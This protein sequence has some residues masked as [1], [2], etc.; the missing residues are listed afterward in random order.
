MKP[1]KIIRVLNTNAV[2]S[3]DQQDREIIITG[4]GIGFKKKKGE[5]LDKSLVEKIYFL[6]NEEDNHRLQEVVKEIS[7]KYLEIAGKVVTCAREQN[8]KIKDT[9]YVTLTDHINSAVER[10]Q[11]G[12]SLKNMMRHEIKKF[13]PQEYALGQKAIGWIEK[14]TGINLGDDEAAF[15]AMHIVSSEFETSEVSDVQKITEL[16]NAIVKIV[17]MHFKIDFHE[18][19]VSYQRFLTHL[20]FF[21]ARVMD[22]E[23]YQDSM[24]EI[25]RV[26][27]VQN[28]RAYTGVEKVAQFIE[29][30]H[31]Y[32]L[33]IDEE[34]Y[35]LIHI[36][37][38]LDEQVE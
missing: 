9:L 37:R 18:D 21:S 5:E 25:Y 4:A 29:K 6:K 38:I 10:F 30:Q 1:V 22:G 17:K 32:R 14:K 11:N 2:V 8:L 3:T 35:L 23:V 12:I 16:I 24:E 34:L 20:K 28:C 27:V 19:S 36:K 15:I 33:S 13:Y 31:G 26:M 7:E